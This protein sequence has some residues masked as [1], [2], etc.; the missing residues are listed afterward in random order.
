MS[1]D[2]DL[3]L[4][5]IGRQMGIPDLGPDE[6][7]HWILSSDTFDVHL[8]HVPETD[9]VLVY[10]RVGELP[11]DPPAELLIRL[12]Q[13]NFF[14]RETAGCTLG[15]DRVSD[16]IA[17]FVRWSLRELEGE[18]FEQRLLDFFEAT[19]LWVQRLQAW[20]QDDDDTA[21]VESSDALFPLG[22]LSSEAEC[23]KERMYV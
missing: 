21:G 5:E 15:L 3:A 4:K 7:G 23:S 8:D 20:T 22:F 9:S 11:Q 16:S 19:D 17:L 14:V 18:D 13:A 6:D 2:L 10:S 1:F 12:L